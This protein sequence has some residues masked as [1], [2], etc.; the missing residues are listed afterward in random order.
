MTTTVDASS[1]TATPP[2]TIQVGG[3]T[4]MQDAKG[5]LVP[6]DLVKPIDRLQDETVRKMIVYA[7]DLSG[8]I[9][10][11]KGHCFDDVGS[12]QALVEQEYGA[13]L[14][15]RKGNLTLTTVDGTQKVTIQVADQIEFGPELQAAK[16][17]VDQC[18]SEW[19]EGS[20]DELRAIVNRAFSVDKEGQI[21]RSELFML[22]RVAIEDERWMRA[23]DAIRDSIRVIGS[24]T[25][26]RFYERPAP[27]AAWRAV[28]IDLA[29]AC[30]RRRGGAQGVVRARGRRLVRGPRHRG[31]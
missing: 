11:F 22:L 25:Y 17:L 29:S 24:K 7:R 10:R 4:Y 26:I 9:A 23:M 31:P 18:L 5:S 30:P 28:T 8:Q 3:K 2:G 6:V 13:T 21:N 16:K 20:R 12:L 15:G 14:G 27:D 1:D 19:A